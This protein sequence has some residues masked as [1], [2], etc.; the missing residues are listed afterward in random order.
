[1]IDLGH[2]LT[3]KGMNIFQISYS[4][5]MATQLWIS[6]RYMQSL[7]FLSIPLLFIGKIK[8]RPYTLL[9]IFSACTIFLFLSIFVLQNFPDCYREGEGLT[10]FKKASEYMICCILILSIFFYYRQRDSFD[11]IFFSFIILSILFTIASEISFTLYLQVDEFTSLLGHIWKIIAYFFVYKAI[12]ELGLQKPYDLLFRNLKQS[13]ER[14][15]KSEEKYRELIEDLHDVVFSISE[16]GEISYISPAAKAFMEYSPQEMV[17]KK[18]I[19]FIHPLDMENIQKQIEKLSSDKLEGEY[20]LKNKSGEYHWVHTC[21]KPIMDGDKRTGFRGVIRDITDW[22]KMQE[23][24]RKTENTQVLIQTAGAAAHEINQPL[25]AIVGFTELL[26]MRKTLD[27]YTRDKLEKIYNSSKNIDDIIKKMQ[28]IHHYAI[29]SYPCGQ[30]IV[31]FD[32]SIKP[33]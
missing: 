7:I 24:L 27:P 25:T 12:I 17:G 5:N 16:N 4:S 13:E 8:V 19:D 2:T 1:M 3:Y 14:L 28:N 30:K 6:A 33:N 26:L 20:R 31:D 10:P 21:L 11:P 32:E 9:C 23:A 18:Y 22:K 29:K 15:K